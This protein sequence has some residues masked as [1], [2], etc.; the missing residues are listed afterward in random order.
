MPS[1]AGRNTRSGENIVAM[2]RMIRKKRLPSANSFTWLLPLRCRTVNGWN[3]TDQPPRSIDI[4]I[5]VG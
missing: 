5:V 3:P 1:E 4:V 2:R